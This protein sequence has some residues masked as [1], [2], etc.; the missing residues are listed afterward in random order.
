MSTAYQQLLTPEIVTT[1]SDILDS[2]NIALS[3][4]LPADWAEQ[5]I[6]MPQGSAYPGKFSLTYRDW[7]TLTRKIN[8][9]N[10]RRPDR[11]L[12]CRAHAICRLRNCRKPRLDSVLAH[13][14]YRDWET[15]RKS[16]R[17]NSSHS[18]KSRMPS[19]A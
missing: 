17:L 3:D 4:I 9:R 6:T 15:D 7:E 19:S 8:S 1:L 14:L 11:L 16:T 2:C 12:C 10:E 13:L 18:A 5:N